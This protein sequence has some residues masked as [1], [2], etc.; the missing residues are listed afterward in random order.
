MVLGPPLPFEF[1]TRIIKYE[2]YMECLHLGIGVRPLSDWGLPSCAHRRHQ[3][4]QLLQYHVNKVSRM[5]FANP[6]YFALVLIAI[7]TSC[8]FPFGIF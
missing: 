8:R 3:W 1:E 2:I 6:G 5:A 7:R 4:H